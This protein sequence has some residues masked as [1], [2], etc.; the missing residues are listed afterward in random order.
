[1][2]MDQWPTSPKIAVGRASSGLVHL[3]VAFGPEGWPRFLTV[4]R[5]LLSNLGSNLGEDSQFGLPA[6]PNVSRQSGQRSSE[7]VRQN[8]DWRSPAIFEHRVALAPRKAMSPSSSL[9]YASIGAQ[10]KQEGGCVENCVTY[11]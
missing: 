2:E 1:M 7:R 3:H 8:S 10:P 11:T 9:E 6:K 5:G 4:I